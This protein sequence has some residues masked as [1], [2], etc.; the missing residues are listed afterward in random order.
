MGIT[1]TFTS[2]RLGLATIGVAATILSTACGDGASRSPVAPSAAPGSAVFA[3][4]AAGDGASALASRGD[5]STLGRGG[6]GN[7]NGNGGGN[8][9]GNGNGGDKDKDGN[10]NGNQ[11]SGNGNGGP[12]SG[13]PGRSQETRVVGFVSAKGADTI[14]VNDVT[15]APAIDGVIRHGN[16]SLTMADIE[17]GDHVQARGAMEG[18]T[19]VATEIKVQDTGRD[20][21]DDDDV[22]EFEGVISGL[23]ATAGCPVVTFNLGTT[24]VT[25]SAATLFDDVTCATLADNMFVEVHGIRQSDGSILATRVDAEAGPDEVEGFVFEFSGAASCPAATFRVGPVPSLATTVTTTASTVFDGVTCATLAN[26]ARVEVEG[27]RQPN[28]SITAARV[29][30]K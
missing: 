15:V 16:R 25:T 11:G 18:T 21:D 23:S 20:N 4:D 5:L 28:G 8:G 6:N 22:D 10:D 9:N 26:G 12:G 30:L 2:A 29:E 27:T 3:T 19:L 7:G 14:V 17:V 24:R 1:R 13:G